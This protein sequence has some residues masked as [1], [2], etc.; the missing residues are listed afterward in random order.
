MTTL[1]P[2]APEQEAFER[3]VIWFMFEAMK[4]V[5]E[6]GYADWQTLTSFLA[7]LLMDQDNPLHMLKVLRDDVRLKMDL[8]R[9]QRKAEAH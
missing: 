6:A 8:M 3:E 2:I 7:N 4:S 5:R 9:Q 1:H